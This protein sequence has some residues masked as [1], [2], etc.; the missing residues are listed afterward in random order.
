MRKFLLGMS[1]VLAAGVVTAAGLALIGWFDYTSTRT[2]L[3]RLLRDQAASLRQTVAAAARA[4]DAAGVQAEAQIGER[5]LDNARLLAEIDRRGALQ[6]PFLDQIARRNRLFR[7]TVFDARGVPERST[8]S[9]GFAPAGRGFGTA[10]LDR[11]LSGEQQ[12][13]VTEVHEARGWGGGAR[14]GAAVR[15]A[16]GG[17]IVLTADATEIAALSRQTSLE[18]LL[19]DIAAG[20]KE[21]AF[22]VLEGPDFRVAQGVLPAQ[23]GTAADAAAGGAGVGLAASGQ[24]TGTATAEREVSVESR[25][26]LEV[27]GPISL[28]NGVASLRLGLRLD[29]VRETER[30]LLTRLAIS[31]TV[32][33][34]VS[35][36][37]LWSI[38]LRR[39]YATLSDKHTLAEAALRRR[40][41][42]SAMGELAATVAH[43]VRNP[44]NAVAMSAKRLRREFLDLVRPE[45]ATDAQELGQ[46]LDVMQHETSRID[47]IVQQFLEYARPPAL[48]PRP[49]DLSLVVGS[50]V[51]AARD[52]A[53]ARGVTLA[54]DVD[55][56]GQAVVDPEQMKQA[57]ENLLR[58][59]IEATPAG[60]RVAVTARTGSREA[61]IEVQDTGAGIAA[62]HLP[63]IFDLY[64]TTKPEGTGVGLAA[65][66]QIVT[67]HGGTIEVQSSP[68]RGTRMTVR[69]PAGAAEQPRG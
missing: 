12:E 24:G 1:P 26:I 3:L 35:I 15:R 28:R 22:V 17:A 43:E 4:N 49:S 51:A 68:G 5:L 63:R 55:A 36:L 19:R 11:V 53:A 39:A 8:A 56:A 34:V 61:V 47:G 62:E 48:V 64:F 69:I 2:E 7:V 66:Q 57:V 59:A 65:T 58:N 38:W 14:I 29:G 23:T 67:G 30:R 44:L 46:L 37:M 45:S 42:L 21:L 60:G 10:L 18:S 33:L 20:T 27:S 9:R 41:R 52:L 13:T 40:D 31:L 32:A 16:G 50:V 54:A 6:Q 25:P